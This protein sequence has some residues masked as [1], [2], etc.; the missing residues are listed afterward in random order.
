MRGYL[1]VVARHT[2]DDNLTQRQAFL[3]RPSLQFTRF[4]LLLLEPGATAEL[5]YAGDV[6]AIDLCAVIGE[7]GRQRSADNLAAIDH[8]DAFSK[9]TL[10]VVEKG[11]IDLEVLEDLDNG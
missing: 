8:G 7:Q 3:Q 10:A 5:L 11:I 6:D 4:V 1:E 9:Q 2:A